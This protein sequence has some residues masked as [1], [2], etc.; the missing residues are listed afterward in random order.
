MYL[1]AY[2]QIMEYNRILLEYKI[3][4]AKNPLSFFFVLF[5]PL[6][7][8]LVFPPI[9]F[10]FFFY[11][12]TSNIAQCLNYSKLCAFHLHSSEVLCDWEI[13]DTS[14]NLILLNYKMKIESVLLSK[15]VL[16]NTHK[17]QFYDIGF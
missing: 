2:M 12:D 13:Y 9:F 16:P 15:G 11:F 1:F 6:L 3:Q 8:P 5:F 4:G 10:S 7:F 17:S 14:L